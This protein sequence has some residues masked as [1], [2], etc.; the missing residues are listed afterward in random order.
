MRALVS[1]TIFLIC[2]IAAAFALFSARGPGPL[3][4]EP[5]ATVKIEPPTAMGATTGEGAS[6]DQPAAAAQAGTDQ[7]GGQ[8]TTAVAP[9]A[10]APAA[11]PSAD[12]GQAPAAPSDAAAS[13]DG[14][15]TT[16]T[17]TSN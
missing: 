4:G 10:P 13:A 16:T 1:T 6:V 5:Q 7:S 15:V 14:A 3:P 11:A 2:L 12:G 8:D 9:P 17:G